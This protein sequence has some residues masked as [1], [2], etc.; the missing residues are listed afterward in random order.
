MIAKPTGAA[1]R[2]NGFKDKHGRINPFF[3]SAIFLRNARRRCA[4]HAAFADRA[5]LRRPDRADRIF[6][7]PTPCPRV[8]TA[9]TAAAKILPCFKEGSF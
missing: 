9:K 6:P 8:A 7:P 3:E 5:S 1:T 4:V 2:I